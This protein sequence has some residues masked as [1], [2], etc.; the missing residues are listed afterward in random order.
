MLSI[1]AEKTKNELE[2][3]LEE[4]NRQKIDKVPFLTGKKREKPKNLSN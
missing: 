1:L 3:H 4:M 2:E